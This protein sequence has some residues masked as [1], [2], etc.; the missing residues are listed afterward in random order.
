MKHA[1]FVLEARPSNRALR[2]LFSCIALFCLV[3]AAPARP[4]I[5]ELQSLRQAD[6]RLAA[7]MYRLSLANAQ[8]C[9]EKMPG[10]G[11]M[12]QALSQ[13]PSNAKSAAKEVFG[14]IEPVSVEVVVSGSP[15]DLGG[16]KP[17]DGLTRMADI[18]LSQ[19]PGTDEPTSADRDR[20]ERAAA[21]LPLNQPLQLGLIRGTNHEALTVTLLPSTICR[22]RFEV[23]PGSGL[24][25]QSD[26]DTI[27]IGDAFIAAFD[28]DALAVIAAHELAHT[29][30]HHRR[31]LE[32]AGVSKGMFSEFGKSLR[33]NR[34]AEEEA[35]R[36]SVYLLANAGYDPL[37][38]PKFWEGRGRKVDPGIFRSRIYAPPSRRA[39]TMREELARMAGYAKPYDRTAIYL[40]RNSPL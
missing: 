12:L 10:T 14:F 17:N 8:L 5:D 40:R 1:K 30:L 37:I 6:E 20:I 24:L 2:R 35:D 39:A 7:V 31:R 11:M 15:A 38:A 9:D 36:L 25:G 33:L 19:T 18:D 34:Q 28:D 27:Q 29:V 32:A 16:V 3:S 26:G 21:N 13:Y 4:L 22:T 23:L